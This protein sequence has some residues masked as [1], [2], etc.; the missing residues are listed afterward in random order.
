MAPRRKG[1][2]TADEPKPRGTLLTAEKI[3]GTDGKERWHYTGF[4]ATGQKAFDDTLAFVKAN[5][6]RPHS[7]IS[8][9]WVIETHASELE[10]AGIITGHFGGLVGLD[11]HSVGIQTHRYF[12]TSS[13][14]QK[15]HPTRR[16]TGINYSMAIGKHPQTSHATTPPV[17]I[18]TKMCKP[19]TRRV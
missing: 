3:K 2:S 16:N 8:Y 17:S 5:P 11:T 9:K 18:T 1:V 19:S 6:Q 4:S 15:C 12:Y 10:E 7:L 14:R 13:V